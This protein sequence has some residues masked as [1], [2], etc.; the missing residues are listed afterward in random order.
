V[1]R[2]RLFSSNVRLA[3]RN[4]GNKVLCSAD[5]RD[6]GIQRMTQR[7][8]RVRDN[9]QFF[10]IEASSA[11]QAWA[12]TSRASGAISYADCDECHHRHCRAC[13]E[14]SV[15]KRFSDYWICHRCGE[16]NPRVS[17]LH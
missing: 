17:N 5:L 10:L 7:S 9:K 4:E 16:L 1:A 8:N 6:Q 2:K 12:K 14:C 15:T 11:K 13:E 3:P